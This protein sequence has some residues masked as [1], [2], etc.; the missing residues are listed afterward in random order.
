MIKTEKIISPL[1]IV[2]LLFAC[3]MTI[4]FIYLP[5]TVTSNNQDMW[6]YVIIS[7][8]VLVIM[9]LPLLYLAH[10]FPDENLFQYCQ[11][12]AG[13]YF[14]NVMGLIFICFFL[15]ILT[16]I[17]INLFDFIHTTV[18]PETPAY[19]ILIAM[20]VP[21]IYT[22]HKGLET[23]G[24]MSEFLIPYFIFVILIFTFLNIPRMDF[25]VFLPVLRESSIGDIFLG[26]YGAAARYYDMLIFA[27]MM[28]HLKEKQ[29]I[30]K[31]FIS[32]ILVTTFFLTVFVV[33]THS[34]LGI[35]F[36]KHISFPYYKFV[37]SIEVFDFIERIESLVVIAWVIIMFIK[38]SLYLY[39]T[40]IGISQIF[41]IENSN[42]IITPICLLL[43]MVIILFNLPKSVLVNKTI[44]ITPYIGS[45]VY[46]VLPLF[47]VVIYF[48]RKKK[49]DNS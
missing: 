49:L 36:S 27:M 4:G 38:F 28:P 1:Q 16:D 21:C 6:I 19:A 11:R 41:R 33:S 22:A 13:K 47:I 35:E 30:N 42:K 44:I 12:I 37:R 18:L 40:A 31:V 43:F 45:L 39:F 15:F 10:K 5:I 46:S 23:L 14:G 29:K 20:L 25:S 32:Y 3:R 24:R 34:V 9:S 8:F 7:L 48:F 26:S 2:L 17:M